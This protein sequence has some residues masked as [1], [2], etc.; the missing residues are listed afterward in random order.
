M[1]T[2]V[3]GRLARCC[4]REL[5]HCSPCRASGELKWKNHTRQHHPQPPELPVFYNIHSVSNFISLANALLV[6]IIEAWKSKA[7]EEISKL[8]NVKALSRRV[9][10]SN[11]IKKGVWKDNQAFGQLSLSFFFF[12]FCL[13]M[14]CQRNAQPHR[15]LILP[16]PAA[17]VFQLQV[18]F[19]LLKYLYI[20]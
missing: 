19:F 12:F 13:G 20:T 6:E 11:H 8:W 9:P 3:H 2:H 10:I 17:L 5:P 14:Q 16:S 18:L 4:L 7:M 1:H 15:V